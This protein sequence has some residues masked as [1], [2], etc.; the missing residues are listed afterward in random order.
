LRVQRVL[1]D[2]GAGF[3]SHLDGYGHTLYKLDF[4]NPVP[5]GDP[6][7]LVETLKFYLRS[8]GRNPHERQRRPRG[9]CWR[10]WT[11][12][13]ESS[14]AGCSSGPRMRLPC[15]RMPSPTRAWPVMRRMVQVVHLAALSNYEV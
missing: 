5:A 3:Q 1:L 8:E 9:R 6:A 10:G 15:A 14:L 2:A 4:V 13:G 11:P 12:R 7:P